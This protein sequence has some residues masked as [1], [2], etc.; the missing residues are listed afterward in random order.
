[1]CE[2]DDD[3]F[4]GMYEEGWPGV[5]TRKE[6]VKTKPVKIIEELQK[7]ERYT[8]DF[9]KLRLQED[10]PVFVYDQFRMNGTNNRLLRDSK[11]LGCA[12]TAHN[13]FVMR[14]YN[15][16][17]VVEQN[18]KLADWRGKIKGEVYAVPPET[19]LTI[20]KQKMNTMTCQ[21][22]MVTVFLTEQHYNTKKGKKHPSIKA[23]MYLARREHFDHIQLPVQAR[24]TIAGRRDYCFYDFVPERSGF[25]G[26]RQEIL[27]NFMV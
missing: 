10:I 19:I 25:G 17:I 1:M 16:P 24:F 27:D 2:A 20:D 5:F 8:P 9:K 22:K 26:N 13:G 18:N 21:R 15:Q 7:R 14:G 23:W 4:A 3:V 11:Y 12:V 6:E